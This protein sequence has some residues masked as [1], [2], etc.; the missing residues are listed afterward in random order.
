[1][2]RVSAPQATPIQRRGRR[3][4]A[5]WLASLL[6][7]CTPVAAAHAASPQDKIFTVGNYPV[8]AR[9]NDAVTAKSKAFADGQQAALRSL[10]KRLV[11][12]T[13]YARLKNL[14]L[15]KPDTLIDGVSVRSERN[16]TTE[17][18]AN[19]DFAFQPQG[20]RDLLDRRGIPY[21]DK[22]APEIVLVP[23]LA[24]DKL[25]TGLKADAWST[26]WSGVDVEHALAPVKLQAKKAG[27]HA[28]TISALANGDLNMLRTFA[29]EYGDPERIVAA[30]AVPDSAAGLL[31]VTLVGRDSVGPIN[32]SKSYRLDAADPGY[33]AELAAVVSL[34]VL[35]GRWKAV[36]VRDQGGGG[37][38]PAAATARPGAGWDPET[39]EADRGGRQDRSGGAS[40]TLLFG[41]EFRAMSEWQDLSR[42][43]ARVPG[44]E[45]VDVAGLSGRTARLIVNYRGSIED[46]A[47]EVP[48]HGL[49][50]RQGSNGW[51]LSAP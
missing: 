28:D 46:L 41:A 45:N 27:I 17:Y 18:I 43:L 35:E 30:I 22:P 21:A 26:A 6:L 14:D 40:G 7:A 49:V 5:A 16:S 44:V 51:V 8:E 32:W 48:R 11:P 1:M 13:A 19:L 3:T 4:P 50:L 36:T 10:L 24:G 15:G 20:I 33:T 12:V 37:Y 38:Q 34:G 42:R 25:P 9:A 39:A 29:T 2:T 23:V 31:K 47:A